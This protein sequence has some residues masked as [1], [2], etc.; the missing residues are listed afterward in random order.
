MRAGKQ[1]LVMHIM[2]NILSFILRVIT[3]K[4]G[5]LCRHYNT[6]LYVASYLKD[7]K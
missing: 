3:S 6:F 4:L 1:I 2:Q 7:Q 5:E